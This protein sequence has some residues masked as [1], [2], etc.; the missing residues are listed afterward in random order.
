M[1]RQVYELSIL[2]QRSYFSLKIWN[3]LK[4]LLLNLTNL[5]LQLL[6]LQL[7]NFFNDLIFLGS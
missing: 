1:P 4:K 6:F 5:I 2:L 7:S 3:L